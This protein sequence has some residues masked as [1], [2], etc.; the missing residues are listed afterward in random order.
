MAQTSITDARYA[1]YRQ[2]FED[3]QRGVFAP[4]KDDSWLKTILAPFKKLTAS[5]KTR[6][7]VEDRVAAYSEG[8]AAYGK[9]W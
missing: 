9:Q 6:L 5:P 7:P 3:A 2:G 4:P 8:H 1:A